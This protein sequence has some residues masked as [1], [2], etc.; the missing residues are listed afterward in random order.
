MNYDKLSR[1]LRYY[2]SKGIMDKVQGKKLTFKYTCDVQNYVRSR[3]QSQNSGGSRGGG[4][5]GMVKYTRTGSASSEGLVVMPNDGRGIDGRGIDGLQ[6]S[7]Q[8]Q[9]QQLLEEGNTEDGDA[10]QDQSEKSFSDLDLMASI[11]SAVKNASEG[12]S[13]MVGVVSQ[14]FVNPLQG[15][16]LRTEGNQ[17]ASA[18][19]EVGICTE[20][21]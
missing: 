11:Q 13:N 7:P 21:V 5:G 19:G 2:Y 14:G 6:H 17:L 10:R 15:G 9:Q 1:G 12:L 20:A 18:G 16:G 8:Q 4:G 3:Q